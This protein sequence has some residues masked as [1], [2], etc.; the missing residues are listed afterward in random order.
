MQD[1]E[2]RRQQWMT[3]Q[4]GRELVGQLLGRGQLGG[5]P[6]ARG[7]RRPQIG[8]PQLQ[9]Q[10]LDGQKQRLFRREVQ[11]QRAFG[12]LQPVGQHGHGQLL[13]RRLGQ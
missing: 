5:L 11:V 12:Q 3:L 8:K 4:R 1:G 7:Q 10:L 9:L 13:K 6:F 2:Q